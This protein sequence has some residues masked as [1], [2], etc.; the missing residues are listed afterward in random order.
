MYPDFIIKGIPCSQ[1]IVDDE[2]GAHL[3]YFKVDQPRS[4]NKLENS[5]NWKDDEEAINFTLNQKKTTG[6]LQFRA[7]IAILKKDG[8]EKLNELP[9]INGNLSYERQPLPHNPY[10]GNILL[11]DG[12]SR[13]LMKLIAAS[14]ALTKTEIQRQ[15]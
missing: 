1:D 8:I 9:M 4:D 10:H 11:N 5:I 2:I 15:Q 12:V 6:E 3:F 14:I 13:K 7:G